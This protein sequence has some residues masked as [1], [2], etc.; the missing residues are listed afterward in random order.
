MIAQKRDLRKRNEKEQ[1]A[2]Q[3]SAA[4]ANNTATDGAAAAAAAAGESVIYNPDISGS[5]V[6]PL[7]PPAQK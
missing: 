7:P 6:I 5:A 3:M 2:M 4:A 1:T